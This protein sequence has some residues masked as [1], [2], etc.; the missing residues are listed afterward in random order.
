MKRIIYI[1]LLL[2]TF[3]FA[4]CVGD[5]DTKPLNDTDFNEGVAYDNIESYY[6]GVSK[7][8]GAFS[9]VGQGGA[10]DAEIDVADA[11][12]SELTRAYWCVQ[13][14][15]SDGVKGATVSDP[16]MM[17]INT[18]TWTDSKNDAIYAVYARSTL[19]VGLVN[20]YL[21]QTEKGKVDGRGAEHSAMWDKIEQFREEAKF[22]RAYVYW[23]GIDIFGNMPFVEGAGVVPKM[24]ERADLFKYV[25]EEL[26]ALTESN[27]INEI[28]TANYPRIDKGAVWSLLARM[29][30]NAE[31]YTGTARWA[32]AKNAAAKVINSGSYKLAPK[33]AELFMADNGENAQAR[34]ESIF[35]IFYDKDRMQ[36]WGGTTFLVNAS[37]SS[38]D[39]EKY[40]LTG[41]DGWQMMRAPYAYV[42]KFGVTDIDYDANINIDDG[43]YGYKCDDSRAMFFIK[44]RSEEML[45]ISEFTQGWS[46]VKYSNWYS[47]RGATPSFTAFSSIDFPMI[48]LGELYLIYAEAALREAGGNSSSN[49]EGLK[50]LNE[51]GVRAK[52]DNH[53]A[54]TS[55]T[56]DFLIDERARELMWEGHRRTDLIRYGLYT[57][58]NYVWEWKGG[59]QEG[60]G[61]SDHYK[62]CPI[63]Q[64]DVDQNP[65]LEQNPGYGGK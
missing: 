41:A 27:V 16:W 55:Y 8:Y 52:G 61:L 48:R 28:G 58:S 9:M 53:T 34:Q 56:L 25:E 44:G 51:L 20:E 1:P 12:A 60:V 5:L 46:V 64:E 7:I 4:S 22:V 32:D 40:D 19:T 11:G 30:L 63:P 15:T 31:V 14:M 38:D 59:V 39:D 23:M 49:S 6:Q 57:S 2:I 54:L 36:T 37:L 26:L 13:E 43:Y 29:Y 3:I 18:N 21:R 24:I 17:E 50:L 33:Y 10:G 65:N 47:N 35:S 45:D 42:E 62:I